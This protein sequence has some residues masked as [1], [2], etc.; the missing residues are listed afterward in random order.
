[1]VRP[2]SGLASADLVF[3]HMTEGPI[4]R[5]SALFYGDTPPAIGPIRSARLID[6]E[7]PAM[8]DAALCFSGASIGVTD[9]LNEADFRGRLLHSWYPG[10]YRTGEDKPF[11]HTFYADPQGFWDIMTEYGINTP[12]LSHS[13]MAFSEVLPE[14]GVSAEYVS[15]DYKDWTFVEWRYDADR[16]QWLR[17]ADDDAFL[18]ANSGE[19]IAASN[20][21]I[22]FAAHELDKTICEHQ[23]DD[24]CYAGSTEIQLWETGDAIILRDGQR[25]DG[26]WERKGRDHMLTFHTYA[27]EVIPLQLGKTWFQV[28]AYNYR[29]LVQFSE[30]E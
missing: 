24:K 2:Q 27:G 15:I 7:L 23:Q 30:P 22:L 8:Y 14:N 25:I 18:D 12:P 28:V 3:E 5:F 4:T 26:Y 20:V 21:V 29:D 16:A 10:Y 13:Q 19:Q 11:E 9:R 1:M 6:L 17:W